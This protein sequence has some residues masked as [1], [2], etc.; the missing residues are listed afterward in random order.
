MLQTISFYLLSYCLFKSNFGPNLKLS[1]FLQV[2]QFSV[3]FSHQQETKTSHVD[4]SNSSSNVFMVCII[5]HTYILHKKILQRPASISLLVHY[6][7]KNISCYPVLW[8]VAAFLNWNWYWLMLFS[9]FDVF[10]RHG[11]W[12]RTLF[13]RL[14]K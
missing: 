11:G 9:F 10:L 12:W 2:S 6:L 8:T 5:R 3:M 13:Q 14:I 1:Y 7:L 4:V